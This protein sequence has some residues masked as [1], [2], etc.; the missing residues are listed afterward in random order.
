[1]IMEPTAFSPLYGTPGS[2]NAGFTKSISVSA[3]RKAM[4][5]ARYRPQAE[6][7]T[8]GSKRRTWFTL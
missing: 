5:C 4:T 1:M 2:L 7:L 8:F 3:L 6:L